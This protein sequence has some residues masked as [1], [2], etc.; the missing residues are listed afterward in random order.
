[1][2]I[3]FTAST[4]DLLHAGH[5]SMLSEAKSVCDY[6]IVGLHVDPSRERKQKNKPVQSLVERYI[7]LS[8]IKYVDEIIPYETEDDLTEILQAYPIS[9][10]IIGEEYR[11]NNFTGKNLE[12]KIHYN[13]RR[14]GFSTSLL[15]KN[16][17]IAE[18]I[19]R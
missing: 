17:L 4:F 1:M 14:H 5:V 19:K 11:D 8:V 7:Q 10:R 9:I 13:K 15:R 12:M 6:L 2:I 18:G 3:G 16:V